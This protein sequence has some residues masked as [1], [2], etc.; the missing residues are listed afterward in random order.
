MTAWNAAMEYSQLERTHPDAI[1]NT[2]AENWR[3]WFLRPKNLPRMRRGTHSSIH[4]LHVTPATAPKQLETKNQPRIHRA[5]SCA[6]PRGMRGRRR[7][8]ATQLSMW[9]VAAAT[10]TDFGGRHRIRNGETKICRK[11]PTKGSDPSTP[12]A[13]GEIGKALVTSAVSAMLAG[14][15][16]VTMGIATIPSLVQ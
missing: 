16:I 2:T 7:P 5:A 13:V 14:S 9:R 6:E 15:A 12:I 1:R 11:L 10:V 3:I 4:V 8:R